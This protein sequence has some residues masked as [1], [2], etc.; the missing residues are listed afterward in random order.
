[1]A[2]RFAHG[3]QS[4][5]TKLREAGLALAALCQ[6]IPGGVVAFFP[7]YALLDRMHRNWTAAGIIDRIAK[8]KPVF[9]ESSTSSGDVLEMYST[10]IKAVGSTGALLLS[11][12]GGR[13]SE[14]INFSD[15]LGR[16]VVMVGV[17]F[18][19]LASPELAERLAYYEGM[20]GA[21]STAV[22]GVIGSMGPRAKELYESLCMR[23]VNQSIGRAIR[24]RNDYAAIVFLDTRYAESRIACKLPTWITGSSVLD[25]IPTAS[26]FGPAMAQCDELRR[27]IAS[28]NILIARG[29]EPV[30]LTIEQMV[31]YLNMMG[32]KLDDVLI[33]LVQMVAVTV[34]ATPTVHTDPATTA[35]TGSISP[36]CRPLVAQPVSR[37]IA[38]PKNK[39]TISSDNAPESSQAPK[40][41]RV[42]TRA[43]DI[44][45]VSS[46]DDDSESG[47]NGRSLARKQGRLPSQIFD[48]SGNEITPARLSIIY[49]PFTL[50]VLPIVPRLYE[51]ILRCQL[52][53]DNVQPVEFNMR[54]VKTPGFKFFVPYHS[55]FYSNLLQQQ[56][57]EFLTMHKN[58]GRLLKQN[59]AVPAPLMCYTLMTLVC[60]P[61]KQMS[62]P[63][64]S[65]LFTALTKKRLEL[66]RVAT[67]KEVR[68]LSDVEMYTMA[69]KWIR[70]LCIYLSHDSRVQSS[71]NLAEKCFDEYSIGCLV[72]GD[73]DVVYD[74]D[75]AVAM[76]MLNRNVHNSYLFLGIL[77]GELKE[78]YKYIM[79]TMVGYT[80]V[81]IMDCLRVSKS[82]HSS[83]E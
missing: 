77:P 3:D 27:L 20:T 46:S 26:A 65:E 67:D 53:S 72:D 50:L 81:R 23:A 6:V 70:D 80:D 14:G 7:S 43:T 58:L 71:M 4:D 56:D 13:L 57:S 5:T 76:D 79:F 22:N 59:A 34:A 31:Q 40:R 29:N 16:A 39:G 28:I 21:Q 61:V 75:G 30:A 17:P 19:S 38:A 82:L 83:P 37:T 11:V 78:Y 24:H 25:S 62:G 32:G 36:L 9:V 1:T 69:E 42:G 64:L 8:R 49:G 12:V 18:P 41:R 55:K 73:I 66:V 48:V 74:V 47:S 52:Y 10:R 15:D 51:L 35:G 60:M 45:V 54:L 44:I 2:L 63:L 33:R 68:L